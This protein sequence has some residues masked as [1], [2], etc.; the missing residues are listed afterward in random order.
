MTGKTQ[1]DKKKMLV[2][3]LCIVLAVIMVG[4]T[5]LAALGIF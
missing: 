5:V 1:Q 3:V 4:S 2:R